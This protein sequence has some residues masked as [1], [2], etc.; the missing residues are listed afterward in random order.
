M[1]MN[2]RKKKFGV[3]Y[4]VGEHAGNATQSAIEAGYS[5][6]TAY[7]QGSRLLK[8]AEVKDVITSEQERVLAHT[9]ASA[10]WI[11]ERAVETVE[12]GLAGD[13]FDSRGVNG[14]LTLLAKRHPEFQEAG[15]T[16]D[17]RSMQLSGLTLEELQALAGR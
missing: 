17:N 9:R 12:R 1:T 8:D 14:A 13:K 11:V 16:I 10:A 2:P 4:A 15:I 5:P 6:D 7:S 3:E